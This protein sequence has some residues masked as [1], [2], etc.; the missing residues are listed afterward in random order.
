[1][2]NEREF[3]SFLA[4][5][6][7]LYVTLPTL[8]TQKPIPLKKTDLD[9][10]FSKQDPCKLNRPCRFQGQCVNSDNGFYCVCP[11][12]H[13]GKLCEYLVNDKHCDK[14]MCVNN[15]TCYSVE[16][17]RR[18]V[19]GDI[20]KAFVV[21]Y[22]CS[23][24][25]G[26][27]GAFCEFS[28]NERI[29][30]QDHCLHHGVAFRSKHV[31]LGINCICVCEPFY[32]GE[33]CQYVS[34]C[35][36]FICYNEGVCEEIILANGERSARC[37]CPQKKVGLFE[38]GVMIT[39]DHCEHV[40]FSPNLTQEQRKCLPCA[41]EATVSSYRRCLRD[42]NA[43][44]PFQVFDRLHEFGEDSF[45]FN[46]AAC[47]PTVMNA[48]DDFGNSALYLMAAC[49]CTDQLTY[50]LFC[51]HKRA[52]LCEMTPDEIAA[53]G[54]YSRCLNGARCIVDP[55]IST[56][57]CQCL[58]GYTGQMCEVKDPCHPNPCKNGAQCVR[59]PETISQKLEFE[60]TCLCS[61]D[62]DV[63]PNSL[64]C[65][66]ASYG[67]CASHPCAPGSACFPCDLY[68][69]EELLCNKD[70]RLQGFQCDCPPG[71][72]GT[73]CEHMYDICLVRGF[74]CI[75]GNCSMDNG[76]ARGFRCDCYEGF[77]GFDCELEIESASLSE[78]LARWGFI[79]WPTIMFVIVCPIMSFGL[80]WRGRQTC[81]ELRLL[82]DQHP[83][84][85]K[86]ATIPP[87]MTTEVSTTDQQ[88]Y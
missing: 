2:S 61:M 13:Y 29:C 15:A 6:D 30:E 10:D 57:R 3:C 34:L 69:D 63:D 53:Y 83:T 28:E 7:H 75:K 9:S 56:W 43:L 25:P 72:N 16:T 45:C 39:G 41:K 23:C 24:L 36:D 81:E 84:K 22:E 35:K 50:G 20:D 65:I 87:Q 51:E 58:I 17:E 47:Y 27:I 4:I 26:F 62:Q 40:Q 5:R 73:V 76:V 38:D 31:D 64:D 60:H 68:G 33:R 14:H 85:G 1:M 71:Y 88:S 32:Y 18:V 74:E 55:F 44:L 12:T 80:Y 67:K 19:H 66:D 59:I 82:G 42:S 86:S 48:S 37:V 79:V 70:E 54:R 52:S 77:G 46:G 78:F 49:N 8:G 21:K 11:S